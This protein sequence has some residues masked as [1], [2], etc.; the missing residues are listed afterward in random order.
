MVTCTDERDPVNQRVQTTS[1]A[2]LTEVS[3]ICAATRLSSP[4]S[5]H[6]LYSESDSG[7]LSCSKWCI[8]CSLPDGVQAHHAHVRY[9]AVYELM[10]LHGSGHYP[11]IRSITSRLGRSINHARRTRCSPVQIGFRCEH[12]HTWSTAICVTNHLRHKSLATRCT[13]CTKR[14]SSFTPSSCF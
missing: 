9:Q 5:I 2:A 7:G 3:V 11:S 14:P 12:T 4:S 6:H 1:V 13:P 10:E 8:F